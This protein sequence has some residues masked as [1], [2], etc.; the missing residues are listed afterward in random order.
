MWE[1]LGVARTGEAGRAGDKGGV[2]K[3][4]K[5]N[6]HWQEGYNICS[7]GNLGSKQSGFL[8]ARTPLGRRVSFIHPLLSSGLGPDKESVPCPS[9]A[10]PFLPG[11]RAEDEAMGFFILLF[12][13]A[14]S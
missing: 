6:L 7:W 10:K 11:T 13:V 5:E 4:G 9:K 14:S 1:Q 12:F 3:K 2:E 8:G